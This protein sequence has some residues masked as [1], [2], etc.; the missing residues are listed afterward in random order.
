MGK[1]RLALWA[2][3]LLFCEGRR[4][5]PAGRAGVA[6]WIEGLAHP[7][8]HWVMPVP[9]PRAAEPDKQ[10]EEIAEAQA[11]LLE[12]RRKQPLYGA[13]DGLAGHFVATAR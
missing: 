9:R 3:Q 12:E 4:P 7:D 6:G 10:V 1:Q 13:P 11:E 2:A 5:S 8:L